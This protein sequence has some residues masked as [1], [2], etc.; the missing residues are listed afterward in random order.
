M[1]LGKNER[2]EKRYGRE[3]RVKRRSLRNLFV[4]PEIRDF[5]LSLGTIRL[6]RRTV[7]FSD[8]GVHKRFEQMSKL[9]E[10]QIFGEPVTIQTGCGH[11]IESPQLGSQ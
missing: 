10:G 11:Q 9:S 7:L 3:G 6:L 4:I 5:R 8:S 2:N 1:Y